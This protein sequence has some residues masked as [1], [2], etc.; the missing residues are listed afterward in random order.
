M[1]KEEIPGS[2]GDREEKILKLSDDIWEYAETKFEEYKSASRYCEL[3]EAEGFH[4]TKGI[5]DMET[6]FV[7]EFGRGKPIVNFLYPH[8]QP[9]GIFAASTDVGDVSQV[10]PLAQISTACYA[11]GKT[12]LFRRAVVH[13]AKVMALTAADLYTDP[14][15]LEEAREEF[16]KRTG[17]KKYV[18]LIP[19]DVKPSPRR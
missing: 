16:V 18:S 6:A 3:L 9:M 15:L 8:L 4:V 19:P 17:G 13:A 10:V 14:G 5:A 7:G 1:K 2:I 12:G 11:Q